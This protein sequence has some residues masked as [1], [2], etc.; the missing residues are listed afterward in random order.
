M[1][2]SLGDGG[3][4]NDKTQTQPRHHIKVYDANNNGWRNVEFQLAVQHAEE[5][6]IDTTSERNSNDNVRRLNEKK[7]KV[8]DPH[9]G[10]WIE[11]IFFV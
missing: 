9:T 11:K 8:F 10:S 2:E 3:F 1:G 5:T 4:Q 7:L 6:L